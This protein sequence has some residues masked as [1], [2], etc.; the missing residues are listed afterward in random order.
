[1]KYSSKSR[2]KKIGVIYGDICDKLIDVHEVSFFDHVKI[3]FPFYDFI[4][5]TSGYEGT[6]STYTK[7][8]KKLPDRHKLGD[9]NGNHDRYSMIDYTATIILTFN[10][11]RRTPMQ[12]WWC[13]VLDD[14]MLRVM[15]NYTRSSNQATWVTLNG[16]IA[17]V[18]YC[19]YDVLGGSLKAGDKGAFKVFHYLSGLCKKVTKWMYVTNSPSEKG[20]PY[21]GEI[22]L[23]NDSMKVT[24][25]TECP[26]LIKN[27]NLKSL[28]GD[29]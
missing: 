14:Y 17:L 7:L 22:Y 2:S 27:N 15:P 18:D 6:G 28:L 16:A 24:L 25:L 8:W 11:P 1:M 29:S 12:Q 13:N 23:F 3:M 10:S 9:S 5:N 20:K 26:K 21:Q 4:D 19:P